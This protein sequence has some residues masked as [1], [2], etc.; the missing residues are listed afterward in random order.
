[1]S[2]I[3]ET[4]APIVCP[5][6]ATPADLAA[7]VPLEPAWM[8]IHPTLIVGTFHLNRQLARPGRV[9]RICRGLEV[10]YTGLEELLHNPASPEGRLMLEG[11]LE[12]TL[13]A[14]ALLAEGPRMRELLEKEGVLERA[15]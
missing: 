14:Q 7:R 2:D 10:F 11:L 4:P 1:M 9:G 8:R 12:A 13:A 5:I 15:S 3:V 6:I